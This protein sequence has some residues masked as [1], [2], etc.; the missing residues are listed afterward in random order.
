[1]KLTGIKWILPL[2]IITD[3]F[4]FISRFSH[5]ST[6][7]MS[8]GAK[9]AALEASAGGRIG[10]YAINTANGSH[11]QYRSNERFPMGCTSKVM[12]VAA[13]LSKAKNDDSLLSQHIK[14][15]KKDLSTW[16]PITEKHLR[17]GMTVGDLCA[18]SISYSDNTA[19]NLLVKNMG[20]LE[21]M[22]I[23]ARSIQNHS[24]RQDNGWPDEAYSGGEGNLKD[25]S[26]PKDM[27]KSLYR[28]AFTDV[29]AHPQ[30]E[31]L[32]SWLKA[33]TTGNF[34]IRAGVFKDW[35]VADKTGTGS[36]YGTTNDIGI[37]WPP[38]CAPIV[39][40]I[41]FTSNDKK[42]LKREDVIASATRILIS[43]FAKKEECIR[44]Q[45]ATG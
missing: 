3:F 28:L 23:F 25:S 42:A 33:N 39:M 29:L 27:A 41:Y 36:V 18:A 9:L 7:A 43:Q 30:K 6:Q 44:K 21:S 15:T 26:T 32:I 12:G 16:S 14:Y 24:F 10:V 40:A 34:R 20:G 35:I 38:T 13:I 1:M 22:N 4:L 11:L 17:T 8:V 19:M 2:I 37:V 5:A 45:I 31:L